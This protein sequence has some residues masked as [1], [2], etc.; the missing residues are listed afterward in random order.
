MLAFKIINK[1]NDVIQS[2]VI[3]MF[4]FY[5]SRKEP[6]L[7]IIV[8]RCPFEPI[9]SI[10]HKELPSVEPLPDVEVL[11]VDVPVGSSL[12]LTPQEKTFLGRCF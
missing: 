8:S 11:D 3:C 4:L 6:V 2:L 7:I 12:S 10:N 1:C 9:L 5:H